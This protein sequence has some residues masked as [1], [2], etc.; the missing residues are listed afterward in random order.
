MLHRI[1]GMILRYWYSTLRSWDRLTDFLYWPIIDLALWG[2]TGAYIEASSNGELKVMSSLI[3]AVI[4]W[5]SIHR[6]QGDISISILEEIWNKNLINVFS[7]PVS[8][9]E[10]WLALVIFSFAKLVLATTV[11]S[12]F[13]Y[14]FYGFNIFVL[15][16]HILPFMLLLT[17]FGWSIGIFVSGVLYRYSTKVQSIAWTIIWLF[18]PFSLVYFPRDV[19]A[20]W[21]QTL[22]M[23]VPSSYIFEEMRSVLNSGQVNWLNLKLSLALSLVYLCLAG[24]FFRRSFDVALKRGL[25][26]LF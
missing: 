7:S 23:F 17:L 11:A 19:L 16:W 10:Q 1:Y 9:I 6:T 2:I 4:L 24:I 3:C 18:A 25:V 13:A 14:L 15:G 5:Y 26:K 20:G 22:S 8:I 21:G 12:F